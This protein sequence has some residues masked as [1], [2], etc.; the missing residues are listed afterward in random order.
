VDTLARVLEHTLTRVADPFASWLA[1]YLERRIGVTA[2]LLDHW[3]AVPPLPRDSIIDAAQA[4][5]TIGRLTDV[6]ALIARDRDLRLRLHWDNGTLSSPQ[7]RV[8]DVSC[9]WPDDVDVTCPVRG[10]FGLFLSELVANAVRHGA[11]GTTPRLSIVCDRVRGELLCRVENNVHDASGSDRGD[12]YGGLAMVTAMARLFEW[13]DLSLRRDGGTFIAAWSM[14][15]S[16]RAG[17]EAD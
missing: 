15:F 13:R 3:D 4:R 9:E 1:E 14:P 7:T 11:P 16:T 12:S 10:G 6:L 17:S 5:A 2:W 8:L